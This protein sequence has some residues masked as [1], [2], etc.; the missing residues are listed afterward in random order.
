[1][2]PKTFKSIIPKM[3]DGSPDPKYGTFVPDG[4]CTKFG[5]SHMWF[6]QGTHPQILPK[7]AKGFIMPPSF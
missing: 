3:A 1:M 6:N 4:F 7:E 5:N 2:Q